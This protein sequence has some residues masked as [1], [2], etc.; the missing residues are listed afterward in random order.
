M[1]CSRSESWL[2]QAWGATSGGVAPG[3]AAGVLPISFGD[4]AIG[5]NATTRF[6]TPFYDN[7]TARTVEFGVIT[8]AEALLTSFTIAGETGN[9]NGN[10]ITYTVRIDESDTVMVITEPSTFA[11]TSTFTPGS[12][13]AVVPG[14]EITVSVTRAAGVG[15]SPREVR[16]FIRTGAA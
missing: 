14:N 6:L 7:G 4:Q 12:P 1:T 9:G 15:T 16:A 2:S 5:A 13:I 10:D 3:S 11:G 8:Q